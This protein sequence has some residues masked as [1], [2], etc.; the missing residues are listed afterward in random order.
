MAVIRSPHTYR[1]AD[2]L[3]KRALFVTEPQAVQRHQCAR[4]SGHHKRLRL[5]KI[6]DLTGVVIAA[7]CLGQRLG[8]VCAICRQ[9]IDGVV[10]I[11]DRAKGFSQ[12]VPSCP[13]A[14]FFDRSS[15][16][17]GAG[18]LLTQPVAQTAACCCSNC[19]APGGSSN[20]TTRATSAAFSWRIVSDLCRKRKNPFAGERRILCDKSGSMLACKIATDVLSPVASAACSGTRRRD[21]VGVTGAF[22]VE[23]RRGL[24]SVYLLSRPDQ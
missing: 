3:W 16:A 17:A 22:R 18:R 11:V 2:P 9:V 15:Q 13:P 12:D 21:S 24:S 8:A 23:P 6:K 20:S 10:G 14:G 4:C 5:G 19:S 7:G 1:R